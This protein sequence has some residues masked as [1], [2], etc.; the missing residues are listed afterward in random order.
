MIRGG[1]SLY[2][3]RKERWSRFDWAQSE[4][5]SLHLPLVQATSNARGS[6]PTTDFLREVPRRHAAMTSPPKG[7]GAA[8]GRG[9][10]GRCGEARRRKHTNHRRGAAPS[11]SS[12]LE[13]HP[14]EW[15]PLRPAAAVLRR[16]A[17]AQARGSA[18]TSSQLVPRVTGLVTAHGLG[19]TKSIATSSRK[20]DNACDARATVARM[21]DGRESIT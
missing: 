2:P 6:G 1:A 20:C 4:F 9:P 11:L 7:R 5:R 3:W 18:S 15:L 17:A 10:R 21:A 16:E 19:K 8:S 12:E 13:E 14:G